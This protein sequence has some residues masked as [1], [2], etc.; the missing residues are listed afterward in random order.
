M[1]RHF[2]KIAW[3]L[4]FVALTVSFSSYL[5]LVDEVQVFWSYYAL[6]ALSLISL[7]YISRR[8]VIFRINLSKR[9]KVLISGNYEVFRKP[10]RVLK[11]E[12]ESIGELFGKFIDRLR[13]YDRLRIERIS[14]T[15][16]ALTLVY[17][18]IKEGVVMVNMEKSIFQCNPVVRS[19]FGIKQET[20]TFE[21]MRN[22]P[23]NHKLMRLVVNAT[24]VKKIPQEG[25]VTVKMPVGSEAK[26]VF[27]R[28]IPLKNKD[29]K[30]KLSFIFISPVNSVVAE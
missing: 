6:F 2:L 24:E 15:T 13:E 19:M 3:F 20:F 8:F 23:E 16:R 18:N 12:F 29:E 17:N 26:D 27:M 10:A 1:S 11:D 4:V 25:V 9:L 30:V 21:S 5:E 14:M 22:Q 7:L 28:I